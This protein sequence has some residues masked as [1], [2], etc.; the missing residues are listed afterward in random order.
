VRNEPTRINP[1]DE[2][3]L[4]PVGRIDCSCVAGQ[5]MV[6]TKL[7]GNIFNNE[8]EELICKLGN[9]LTYEW[10]NCGNTRYGVQDR[11]LAVYHKYRSGQAITIDWFKRQ[12]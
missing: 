7:Y 6:V 8:T 2:A 5:W 12:P 1:P 10:W 3:T 9:G 11:I 4:T